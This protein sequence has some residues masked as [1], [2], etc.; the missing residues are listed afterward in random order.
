[1]NKFLTII[2]LSILSAP[3][4]FAANEEAAPPARIKTKSTEHPAAAETKNKSPEESSKITVKNKS[5]FEAEAGTRNPFWPIGFKPKARIGG[6]GDSEGEVPPTAF[7]VSTI[8]LDTVTHFAI[9]N[10]K[11][12]VE[13]Q[14]FGLQ[15]GSQI[16]QVTVKRIEDGKVILSRHDEEIVVPLRRK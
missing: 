15:V 12:M 4:M 16:Y 14:Q 2:C 5:S 1:M 13:G 6:S 10:G 3:V 8:T 11:T 7:L 9:I